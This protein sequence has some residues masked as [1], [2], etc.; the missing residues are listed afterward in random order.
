MM[1][2]V[3]GVGRSGSIAWRQAKR[4]AGFTLIE[5]LVVIAIIA[6]LIGLLLPAV[7]KV[8]EAA[9][10]IS[11]A[12]NLKQIGL[13][14]HNYQD[15]YSHL[16]PRSIKSGGATWAV[17][18]LPFIEQG[19]GFALWDLSKLYIDQTPAAQQVRV[20]IY[21]CP[22][23]RDGS[24][25]SIQ[26]DGQGGVAGTG[27]QDA[28]HH[29]P[30]QVGDYAASVGTFSDS[31]GASIW[32]SASANGAIIR[33][34]SPDANGR[35]QSQTSLAQIPDGTSNTFLV[36]EKH[37]PQVGLY[38][39][40]YGDSSVYNGWWVPYFCRLA[41]F[42]DPLGLGPQDTSQSAGTNAGDSTQARKFGSWHTGVCGFV[43]CDGSVHYIR[44]SIDTTTLSRLAQR[45]DG[46]VVTL[47][48]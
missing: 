37:V 34:V 33:G 16:P 6:V 2:T 27:G 17:L 20:K 7:Q 43:F 19:N 32:V 25:L 22:S 41:G 24:Q 26:E 1:R 12:N 14:M 5:L 47:P 23:R 46:Q 35:F 40:N 11:C 38:H 18:I 21:T 9:A 28:A 10:R 29:A 4:A 8:R 3:K 30:G 31:T 13:A 48:D 36:G 42:E 39:V 44:S 45:A 15:A